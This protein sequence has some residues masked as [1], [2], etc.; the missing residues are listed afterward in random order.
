MGL[1]LVNFGGEEVSLVISPKLVVHKMQKLSKEL[2]RITSTMNYEGVKCKQ[3]K[4]SE[5]MKI[6]SWDVR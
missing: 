4:T 3:V 5:V 6:V 1:R 2:Q